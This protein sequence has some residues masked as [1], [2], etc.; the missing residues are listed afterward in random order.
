VLAECNNQP[1]RQMGYVGECNNLTLKINNNGKLTCYRDTPNTMLKTLAI[2]AVCLYPPV[3]ICNVL[4]W[5]M[6]LTQ[7]L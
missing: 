5:E 3:N 6:R 2:L 1:N 7:G 4:K